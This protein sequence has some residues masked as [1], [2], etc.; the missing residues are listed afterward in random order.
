MSGPTSSPTRPRYRCAA[1]RDFPLD[2]HPVE[3]PVH[4]DRAR[5]EEEH[6][7]RMWP[8]IGARSAVSETASSTASSPNSVV[9]LMIGFSATD[10]VSLNGSPTVSPTTVAACS[11]GALLLEL[12]LDDLLRVVPRAAG[13]G[14]EHR[15][16]QPE[17]RDRDQI[18]D[19]EVRLDERERER[20]EEDRRGRC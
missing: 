1:T 9:N 19:E 3:R 13:V 14:H 8:S 5:E 18:A 2:A 11:V 6:G 7:R 15:L 10:D 17:Q 20:R 4:E 12:H 16:I